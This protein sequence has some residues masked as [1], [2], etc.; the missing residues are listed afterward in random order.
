MALKLNGRIVF[1]N[2]PG[3][4]LGAQT[5]Q[6][7]NFVK[8]GLRNREVGAFD[9]RFSGYTN[10]ALA[11]NSFI[12]P[13][14][15]GSIS[16]YTRANAALAKDTANLVPAMPMIAT[17]AMALA[18]LNSQLDQVVQFIAS[19]VLAL[20]GSAS[21]AAAVGAQ[22]SATM[23]LAGSALAGGIFPVTASSSMTLSPS[24]TMTAQAFIEASAGGPTPLSPEGLANA[25]LDAL[26]ADHTISGSVGEALSN[27]GSAGNPW[28]AL[29]A[30]NI[31]DGTFGKKVQELL[32]LN[33]Y[34]GLK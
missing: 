31:T 8:G 2:N 7:G 12:L 10:G 32:A 14:K 28:S 34:I 6:S 9:N 15:S 5:L 25:V 27:A 13:Q 23:T 30:S 19:G 16:S 4:Y 3:S 1:G 21:L 20:T 26:L 29:L 24:V 18:V 11:P 33:D 17:S 22:A